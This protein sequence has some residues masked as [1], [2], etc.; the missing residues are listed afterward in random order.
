MLRLLLQL[1]QR[2][3]AVGKSK[4]VAVTVEKEGRRSAEDV[5]ELV[6]TA[7][8]VTEVAAATALAQ[9]RIFRHRSMLRLAPPSV[10]DP[11]QRIHW[12]MGR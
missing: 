9:C 3:V 11:E 10:W 1:R 2:V 4:F 12:T 7:A 8:E 6:M 5:S